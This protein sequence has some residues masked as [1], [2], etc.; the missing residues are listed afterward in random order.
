M[1]QKKFVTLVKL[2]INIYLWSEINLEAEIYNTNIKM[3]SNVPNYDRNSVN[4]SE[5]SI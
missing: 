4:R 3:Q 5:S 2:W 1:L